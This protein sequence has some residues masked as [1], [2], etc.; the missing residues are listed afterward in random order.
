VSRE[1]AIEFLKQVKLGDTVSLL[2][3]Q[4]PEYLRKPQLRHTA[5]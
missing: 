4:E 5:L 1:G 2:V 3:S